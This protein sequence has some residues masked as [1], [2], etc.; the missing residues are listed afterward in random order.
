MEDQKPSI[1]R[2][3][4]TDEDVARFVSKLALPDANCCRLWL[5]SC[6]ANGYGQFRL[7][8]RTVKAHLDSERT[9]EGMP[10]VPR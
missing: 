3:V 6:D 8:P 7:R 2:I 10:I 1:G 4:L 9:R 5:A